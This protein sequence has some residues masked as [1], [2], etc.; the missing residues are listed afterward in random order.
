MMRR[1][2]LLA[3]ARGPLPMNVLREGA[4]SGTSPPA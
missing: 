2:R 3:G 1:P 4:A